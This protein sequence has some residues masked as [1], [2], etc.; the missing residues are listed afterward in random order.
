MH[1]LPR[2]ATRTHAVICEGEAWNQSNKGEK[3]NDKPKKRVFVNLTV[4]KLSRSV[5]RVHGPIETNVC[6]I[7]EDSVI[8]ESLSGSRDPFAWE[9]FAEF[10][11]KEP[12]PSLKLD[13][14][15]S[16]GGNQI[17]E[18]FNIP[19]AAVNILS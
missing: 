19:L 13:E 15:F 1:T 14:Y 4:E 9:K 17:V 8:V 7:D 3:G 2:S 5:E 10:I 18:I 16:I 6:L 12:A 11:R